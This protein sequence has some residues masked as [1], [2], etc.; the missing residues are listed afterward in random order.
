MHVLTIHFSYTNMLGFQHY[1]SYE[2]FCI[3]MEYIVCESMDVGE[4]C[5]Y[6]LFS[7]NF[8]YNMTSVCFECRDQ[9]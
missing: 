2:G 5:R 1:M 4:A 7:S 9:M 6:V 3:C 8:I